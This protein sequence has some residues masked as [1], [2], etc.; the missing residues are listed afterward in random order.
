LLFVGDAEWNKA[1]R[2]KK[3][4]FAWNTAWKLHN[5]ELNKPVDFLKI[6][7]HGSMNS[8]P[9]NDREDGAVTEPSKIL[10]AILPLPV[11]HPKP[12][13]KA[14]VSTERT[15]YKV[16]PRATLLLEIGKRV[17]NTKIY[18]NELDPDQVADLPNY[19]TYE[20]SG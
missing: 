9:W 18:A 7:H 6:G 11:G 19:G 15:F 12:T 5:E 10:D 2:D 14:I 13:A 4:N 3:K 1:Y 8:T 16:I 20:K 17:S